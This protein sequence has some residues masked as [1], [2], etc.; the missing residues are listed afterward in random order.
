MLRDTDDIAK[1]VEGLIIEAKEILHLGC[2]LQARLV[3]EAL[4]FSLLRGF[5]STTVIQ[6]DSAVKNWLLSASHNTNIP[7]LK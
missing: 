1:D 4:V 2:E 5:C 6:W 7:L 3:D